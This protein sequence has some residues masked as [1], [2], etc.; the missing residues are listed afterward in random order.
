MRAAAAAALLALTC[1]R[2]GAQATSRVAAGVISSQEWRVKRAG[3]QAKEEE[4]TGEVRY[5]TGPNVVRCDWALYDHDKQVWRLRGHVATQRT[6]DSGDRVESSGDTGFFDADTKSGWMTARERVS[7]LRQ[8][9]D[10]TQPDHGSAGRLEWRGRSRAWLEDRV[11][12]WGP[13]ADA[14]SERADYDDA[15]GELK[16]TGGRPVLRKHP[17][18][19]ANDDWEGAVKADEVRAWQPQRRLAADGEVVGW[20]LFKDVKEKRR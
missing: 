2:A 20:L 19:D 9:A 13:R 18:W 12:L 14:W 1:S 4:F 17:A 3:G 11:R 6:L 10:G 15:G 8:P 16:L 5:R 7:F